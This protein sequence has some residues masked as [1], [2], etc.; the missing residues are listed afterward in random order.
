VA[1]GLISPL[2]SISVANASVIYCKKGTSTATISGLSPKCPIGFVK[3]SIVA[4]QPQPARSTKVKKTT[5]KITCTS[6]DLANLVFYANKVPTANSLIQ[7]YL[8]DKEAY[9]N[10]ARQDMA[11]GNYLNAN[12]DRQQAAGAQAD[13]NGIV[14]TMENFKKLFDVLSTKCPNAGIEWQGVMSAS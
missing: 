6:D 2:S 11:T 13:A 1:I 7:N 3:T 9:L 5:P 4:T 14:A 8:S 10:Q 12:L